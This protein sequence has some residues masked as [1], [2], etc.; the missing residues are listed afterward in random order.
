MRSRKSYLESVGLGRDGPSPWGVKVGPDALPEPKHAGLEHIRDEKWVQMQCLNLNMLDS[1]HA[2]KPKHVG[3][4]C[5]SPSTCPLGSW[6]RAVA[7]SSGSLGVGPT[8][9]GSHVVLWARDTK[10]ELKRC[11]CWVYFG[12]IF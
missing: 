6:T 2:L 9:L 1:G 10:P 11:S 3:L 7:Q 5:G 8:F 4:E 12:G